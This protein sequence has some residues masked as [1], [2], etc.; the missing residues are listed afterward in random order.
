MLFRMSFGRPGIAFFVCPQKGGI[1]LETAEVAGLCSTG[2]LAQQVSGF[3][4]AFFG[5]VVSNCIAGFLLEKP[6]HVIGA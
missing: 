6:H 2:A 3:D 4:Q 5:N 1:V